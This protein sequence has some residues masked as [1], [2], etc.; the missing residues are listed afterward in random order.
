MATGHP[1][2]VWMVMALG[3]LTEFLDF[4]HSLGLD[5]LA[6]KKR[7]ILFVWPIHSIGS[8]GIS[9]TARRVTAQV[10]QAMLPKFVD[11]VKESGSNQVSIY[12]GSILGTNF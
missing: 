4:S 7:W 10:L 3:P 12:Q 8:E 5:K 1:R 2:H 11:R 6:V 9:N